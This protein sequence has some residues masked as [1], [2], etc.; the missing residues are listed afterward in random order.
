MLES[1]G[2]FQLIT[3]PTRV[4]ENS[5][6]LIDHIFPDA[7]SDPIFSGIILNDISDHFIIYCAI[8][9]KSNP[10]SIKHQKYFCRDIKN[11]DIESYLLDLD[12]NM[13]Q[14]KNCLD[15]INADNF[16]SFLEIL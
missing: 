7:L 10:E 4:T 6:S 16:N 9:L 5:T 12:K 15:C 1:N 11:F 14:F 3:K 8:Y 2:V 13:N